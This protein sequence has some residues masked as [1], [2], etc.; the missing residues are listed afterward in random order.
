MLR[1]L[2][3]TGAMRTVAPSSSFPIIDILDR[4]RFIVSGCFG[5][6]LVHDYCDIISNFTKAV[7]TL[8]VYAEVGSSIYIYHNT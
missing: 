7:A 5:W 4:F 1:F 6:E 2:R 8:N 3:W